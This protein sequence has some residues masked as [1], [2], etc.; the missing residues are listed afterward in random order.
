MMIFLHDIILRAIHLQMFS[1]ISLQ[2]IFQVCPLSFDQWVTVMK[3]S[4]PVILLDEF[5]KIVARNY[6]D[7]KHHKKWHWGQVLAIVVAFV[8]YGYAWFLHEVY[9]HEARF[10]SSQS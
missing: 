3:F 7:G 5:L 10:R 1:L 9:V 2:T 4:L 8:A 6:T